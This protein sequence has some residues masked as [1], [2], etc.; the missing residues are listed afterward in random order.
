MPGGRQQNSFSQS[1]F[2]DNS[3]LDLRAQRL[4]TLELTGIN[5]HGNSAESPQTVDN[6]V[7][8]NSNSKKPIVSSVFRGK[9]KYQS[10]MGNLREDDNEP[11]ASPQ[12]GA[13]SSNKY[14][15]Y[16]IAHSE[17]KQNDVNDIASPSEV[18]TLESLT[19]D[20]TN[21]TK[22][23]S[24]LSMPERSSL[25]RLTVDLT[26]EKMNDSLARPVVQFQ[27]TSPGGGV[28]K[29]G[30][31]G[32]SPVAKSNQTIINIVN[33]KES[34]SK[35]NSSR[36]NNDDASLESSRNN[37]DDDNND[38]DNNDNNGNNNNGEEVKLHKFHHRRISSGVQQG[39]QVNDDSIR[40]D[41][42]SHVN[43]FTQ[44]ISRN[45]NNNP[46]SKPFFGDKN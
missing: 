8:N 23:P 5:F 42:V 21:N 22:Q 33:K 30:R 35:N 18:I 24:K 44:E 11:M 45:N 38:N 32:E 2:Q 41:S 4:S 1:T 20:E 26:D 16:I 43:F 36:D 7:D 40:E 31:A 9:S 14:E 37:D 27:V 25:K 17:D 28:R 34:A 46:V 12:F 19:L 39:L 6:S 29:L 3:N 10:N 15:Q 13:L